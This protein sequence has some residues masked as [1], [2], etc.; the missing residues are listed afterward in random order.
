MIFDLDQIRKNPDEVKYDYEGKMH[1]DL[2]GPSMRVKYLGESLEV[3]SITAFQWWNAKDWTDTDFSQSDFFRRWSSDTQN[4]ISEELRF[5]SR[6]G[7]D[8]WLHD[9]VSFKWMTGLQAS[10]SVLSAEAYDEIRFL[11]RRDWTEAELTDAGLGLFGQATFTAAEKLDL[12]TG[13]RYDHE[14]KKADLANFSEIAAVAGPKTTQTLKNRYSDWVPRVSLAYRITPRLMPYASLAKGF[15]AGGYDQNAPPGEEAFKPETIWAYETGIKTSWAEGLLV[16]NASLFQVEWKDMQLFVV[17]P[18]APVKFYIANAGRSRSRGGEIELRA[19]PLS[20]L[21]VLGG[22]G[23]TDA[24]FLNH[25]DRFSGDVRNKSLINVPSYTWNSA[26]LY[27][28]TLLDNLKSYMGG[29][30]TGMGPYFFDAGN[31]RQQAAYH[32]VNLRLG[33]KGAH[34]RAEVWAKNVFDETYV[35]VAFQLDL[36]PFNPAPFF[37]ES[38]IPRTFGI[39]LGVDF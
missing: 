38:G 2:I 17:N 31:T 35:P 32:L 27:S 36:Q 15:R 39:T 18:L 13:I 22:L 19:R 1:R 37:G 8:L 14:Y 24:K 25:I 23:T 21:E 6:D 5:A 33:L 9:A 12:T 29:G 34:W 11:A 16:L 28:R 10:R 26:L 4:M 7:E 20:G 3:T 30:V